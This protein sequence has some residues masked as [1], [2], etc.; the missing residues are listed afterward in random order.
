MNDPI[1]RMVAHG[2][3]DL[4]AVGDVAADNCDAARRVGA[5]D[6][7]HAPWIVAEI[8]RHRPLA[9]PEQA[10]DYPGADATEGARHQCRHRT[11]L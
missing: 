5:D 3:G 10:A 11:R 8:E 9:V 7:A 1:D 2:A 4:L 6:H